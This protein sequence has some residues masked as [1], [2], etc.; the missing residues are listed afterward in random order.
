MKNGFVKVSVSILLALILINFV[1]APLQK[2]ETYIYQ[3]ITGKKNQVIEIDSSGIPYVLYQG[4]LGKQYNTVAIAEYANRISL[5][6]DLAERE[7]FFN[8]L[9]WFVSNGHQLNDSSIIFYNNYDWSGYKMTAPWR[10][11]MNQTRAVQVFLKA[12]DLSSDSVYLDYARKALNVLYVEVKYGGV[13]YIDSSGYWYEEYADDNA[14][15]SRVLNGMIVALEGISDFY[16]LTRDPGAYKL[17]YNGVKAI[18][19]NLH[20]YDNN[21]HS[22][23]DILKKPASPWYHKFHIELLGF[24]YN[25]THEPLFQDYV[26]KW[27]QYKEPA[28]LA[29]L[30]QKPTRI[31]IFTLFILFASVFVLVEIV[32]QLITRKD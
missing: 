28:Y 16:K 19:S 4:K 24:L 9:N 13:T 25:E 30:Y 15:A 17:F 3:K 11:A 14:P 31:G 29:K 32:Y 27:S 22:N 6:N 1:G 5:N 20:L 26:Q 10:S 8:C 12:Y 23:Y 18:K 21:G 7:K 2:T